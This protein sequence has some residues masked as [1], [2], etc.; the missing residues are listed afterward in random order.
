MKKTKQA[1][2]YSYYRCA[3]IDIFD[4]QVTLCVGDFEECCRLIEKHRNPDYKGPKMSDQL[5][6]VKE[7]MD[8]ES[9]DANGY[10]AFTTHI[11]PGIFIYAPEPIENYLLVHEISH[12]VDEIFYITDCRDD[13]LRAY[14]SGYLFRELSKGIAV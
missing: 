1:V 11:E 6:R 14:L 8:R 2:A 5:R 9:K 10:R 7:Q 12:A 4:L 3:T 13:E